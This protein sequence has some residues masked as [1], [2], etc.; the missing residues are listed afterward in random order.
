MKLII[1]AGIFSSYL[2]EKRILK[3]EY[4]VMLIL[5]KKTSG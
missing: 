3:I 1:I 4:S 2:F 5:N